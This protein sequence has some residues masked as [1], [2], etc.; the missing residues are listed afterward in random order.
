MGWITLPSVDH[1]ACTAKVFGAGRIKRILQYLNAGCSRLS[2]LQKGKKENE[3][4]NVEGRCP[5]AE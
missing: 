1:S 4:E 5:T 2:A 3:G